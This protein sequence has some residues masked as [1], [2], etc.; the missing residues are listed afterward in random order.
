MMVVL[1]DALQEKKER[2]TILVSEET[3]VLLQGKGNGCEVKLFL[4]HQLRKSGLL[5]KNIEFKKEI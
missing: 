4:M 2:I 3:L 1:E 5:D